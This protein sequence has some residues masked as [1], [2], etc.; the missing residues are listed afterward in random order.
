MKFET[1]SRVYSATWRTIGKYR[2]HVRISSALSVGRKI[3]SIFARFTWA[4]FRTSAIHTNPSLARIELTLKG[5]PQFLH[6]L[7]V[8][9]KLLHENLLELIWPGQ[10]RRWPAGIPNP[11]LG[12]RW[13]VFFVIKIDISSQT[14]FGHDW[15]IQD[16]II[17]CWCL[18]CGGLICGGTRKEQLD[19]HRLLVKNIKVTRLV[20]LAQ[21]HGIEPAF[22]CTNATLARALV[23]LPITWHWAM[24][25]SREAWLA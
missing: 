16:S 3:K 5:I 4:V 2:D 7:A 9:Q 15:S 20:S 14:R 13:T 8:R 11:R 24:Q 12:P 10:E 17:K 22:V 21:G 6:L 18:I 25:G 23:N 19:L 1:K